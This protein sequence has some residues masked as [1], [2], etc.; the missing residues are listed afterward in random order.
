MTLRITAATS[1]ST[2]NR[3]DIKPTPTG[4]GYWIL[5]ESGAVHNKGDAR[6]LGSALNVLQSGENAAAISPTPSGNGYWIFTNR[7]R[8][9]NFGDAQHFGDMASTPLNG[10]V[11]GSVATPPATATG[12]SP[13]TAGSSAFGDAKFYG[14][15]GGRTLNKPVHVDGARPRRFR[16]L[17]RRL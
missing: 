3:V 12:W 14:S 10:A 11:L 9:L 4:K 5:A 13:P 16:L 15:M 1:A 6:W 7:G 2:V 17:A 8:V